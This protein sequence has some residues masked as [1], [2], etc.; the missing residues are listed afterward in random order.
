MTKKKDE[1]QF[2][3][4]AFD[5]AYRDIDIAQNIDPEEVKGEVKRAWHI[6]THVNRRALGM[7]LVAFAFVLFSIAFV[8]GTQA[9]LEYVAWE[10]RPTF[11]ERLTAPYDLETKLPPYLLN[12]VTV[13]AEVEQLLKFTTANIELYKA[14]EQPDASEQLAKVVQLQSIVPPQIGDFTLQWSRK[15][16]KLLEKCLLFIGT[17]ESSGCNTAHSPEFI[18]PANFVDSDGNTL[19]LIMTKFA[20]EEQSEAIIKSVYAYARKVG[21]IGNFALTDLLEVDYFYSATRK[22][23]SF[24]WLNVNWVL[25]VSAE[26]MS[27]ID[28]FMES[29]P[30]YED[31]P[32]LSDFVAVQ[33]EMRAPEPVAEET[34]EPVAEETPESEV[35][36][37]I[38]GTE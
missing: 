12:A 6:I 5:H 34:P 14:D 1:G 15:Q 2:L 33:I 36:D 8:I 30:L 22:A 29:F 16:T 35:S 19:S 37:A 31:N 7:F 28:K 25:S 9:Y 32:N 17:T 11:T 13:D 38:S 24:T 4:K 10:N 21:R 27:T 26:N 18:E 20:D 23:V 3:R